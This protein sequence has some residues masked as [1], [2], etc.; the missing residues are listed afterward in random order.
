MRTNLL[1]Q[2]MVTTLLLS[3]CYVDD[4]AVAPGPAVV[5]SDAVL[6]EIGPGVEVIADYDAPI[7]FFDDYYWWDIG[8]I[9]YWSPWY[10][11]GWVR[12]PHVPPRIAGIA[13]PEQYAHYRP[14]GWAP[15]SARVEARPGHPI[16]GF[17]GRP[18]P[19]GGRR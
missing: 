16:G 6:V 12:A 9:W 7:F 11:G 14:A 13:H 2:T 5:A 18:A 8:G 4:E 10:R 17:R 15:R 3:N 1:L 19:H